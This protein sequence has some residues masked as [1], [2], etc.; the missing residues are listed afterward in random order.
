MTGASSTTPPPPACDAPAQFEIHVVRIC[1][2][3]SS[4][5]SQQLWPPPTFATMRESFG[6]LRFTTVLAA[7]YA[8]LMSSWRANSGDCLP[9]T[10]HWPQRLVAFRLSQRLIRNDCTSA[11]AGGGPL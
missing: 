8:R 11:V 10:W 9:P 3:A 1:A 7:W 5:A 2:H 6:E 4:L